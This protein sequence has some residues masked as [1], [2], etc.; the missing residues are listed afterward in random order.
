MGNVE[1]HPG[2]M[3]TDKILYFT[4]FSLTIFVFYTESEEKT[5]NYKMDF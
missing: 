2:C 4:V 5:V 1:N 3:G